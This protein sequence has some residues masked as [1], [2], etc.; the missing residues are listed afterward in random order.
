MK[1]NMKKTIF[2]TMLFAVF[3]ISLTA[4][5]YEVRAD[6]SLMFPPITV[7]DTPKPVTNGKRIIKFRITELLDMFK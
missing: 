5:S 1:F 3:T 2:L 7:S 4:Y 6:W